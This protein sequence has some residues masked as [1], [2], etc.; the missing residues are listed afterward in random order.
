[1]GQKYIVIGRKADNS[2]EMLASPSVEFGKMKVV[3]HKNSRNEKF[4]EVQMFALVPHTRT[5]HPAATLKMEADIKAQEDAAKKK[6][7]PAADEVPEGDEELALADAA[8]SDGI[9]KEL[10]TKPRGEL[11]QIAAEAKGRTAAAQNQVRHRGRHPG[12][13]R[14]QKPA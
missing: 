13:R 6:P 8:K 10:L 12:R 5:Y 7:E 1:M 4:D 11:L 3:L 2:V 9:R 14:L